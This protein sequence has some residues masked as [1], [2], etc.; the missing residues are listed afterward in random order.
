MY[1]DPDRYQTLSI[2]SLECA[3]TEVI[4]KDANV[5]LT[6]ERDFTLSH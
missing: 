5:E 1:V 2:D 4:W 3:L 6:T